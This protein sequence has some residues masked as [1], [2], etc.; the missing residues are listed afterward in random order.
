[1]ADGPVEGTLTP[2]LQHALFERD[3][4]VNRLLTTC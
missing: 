1:M 3:K 2:E 4:A